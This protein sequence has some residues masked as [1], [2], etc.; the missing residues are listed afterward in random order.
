MAHRTYHPYYFAEV[1]ASL[2]AEMLE[3]RHRNAL[4]QA[5]KLRNARRFTWLSSL[6][7][8]VA[9]PSTGT[10]GLAQLAPAG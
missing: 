9:T 3:R 1:E 7:L 6:R 4:L 2:E 5:N 10:S 8:P